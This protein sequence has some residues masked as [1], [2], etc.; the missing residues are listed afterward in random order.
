M[1]GYET[2]LIE[3]SGGV[4]TLTLNRPAKKNAMSP[5]L[6]ADVTAALKEPRYDDDASVS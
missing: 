1:S 4:A 3:R 6:H 2:V 5:Q